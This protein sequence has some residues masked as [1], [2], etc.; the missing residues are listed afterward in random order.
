MQPIK[1]AICPEGLPALA[2]ERHK[3]MAVTKIEDQGTCARIKVVYEGHCTDVIEGYE[4]PSRHNSWQTTDRNVREIILVRKE[5]PSTCPR[6][7]IQTSFKIDKEIKESI[8]AMSL[9]EYKDDY[10]FVMQ[11][12]CCCALY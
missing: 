3:K 10:D 5:F 4:I 6:G 7:I 8:V 2:I 12:E 11:Q 1:I 9:N